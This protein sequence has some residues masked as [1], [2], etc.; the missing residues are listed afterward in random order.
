[1]TSKL[2]WITFIPFTLL[3]VAA[4]VASL[5]YLD[6]NGLFM[7][8]NALTLS[9]VS[10]AC[11]LFVLLFAV[12]FCLVDK[13]TASVY[14]I[15]RNIPASVFG[16]LLAV[17]LACDG[18][19]RAFVAL[20]SATFSFLE[21]TEITL[22]ILCAVV[23]VVLGL[24]HFVGN[25][26]VKGI[27]VFYL[28]PAL[29]SAFRLVVCFLDFTT[30]SVVVSDISILGCYI[31][32]SLFLF[33]YAMI[34]ALMKGKSPVRSALIY[35]MPAITVL[36][37]YSV[38]EICSTFRYGVSSFT[39][40]DSLPVF[41]LALLGL[42]ILSFVIE[43]S[44]FVKKKDEI[45]FLDEEAEETYEDVDDSDADI[46]KALGNSVTNGNKP[47]EVVNDTVTEGFNSDHLAIGDEVYIEV[48]QASMNSF[49][50]EDDEKLDYKSFVYGNVPSDDE[51][52]LPTDIKTESEYEDEVK[53]DDESVKEFITD[54]DGSYYEEE[55][56]VEEV[57]EDA[58]AKLDRIDRLILEITGD[59]LD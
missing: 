57:E 16:I 3:A 51:F 22:T 56:E 40:F 49:G 45:E 30:V 44:V 48:A 24:N 25:G 55:E 50:S 38:Y 29:W 27:S 32:S 23:F 19:N 59:D 54:E 18:A 43:M 11:A 28:V 41:E 52:I 9:Y 47:D 34:I 12:I 14:V 33:N 1:M 36:M 31:F 20:R 26:G 53:T 46:I 17:I 37:S 8:L 10:I 35:G 2:S 6:E 58:D 7:G 15:K 4:R 21:I 39:L 42:Y 5:F 13:K